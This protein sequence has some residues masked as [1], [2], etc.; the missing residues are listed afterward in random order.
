MLAVSV[1][2]E[3]W[4]HL[5]Y[6]SGSPFSTY[7]NVNDFFEKWDDRY[8]YL[9]E[10]CERVLKLL[11]DFKIQ[12]TFFVVADVVDNYPE[13]AEKIVDGGHE[14]ACHG[15]HHECAID[16]KTKRAIRGVDNFERQ[17]MVAK[18]KLEEVSKERIIG[19]RAPSAYIAGWMIDSLE[20]MGFKYDSSVSVNSLY[21]KSDEKLKNVTTVPYYPVKGGL[22]SGEKRD[23]IEMP[24]PYFKLVGFKFPTG[25]GPFLRFGGARYIKL[26]LRQS[27]KRGNTVF[28]FH[29]IDISDERFPGG[30]S[31]R[32]PFYWAIKGKTVE[33]RIRYILKNIDS[34]LGTCRDIW[35][36]MR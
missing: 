16:P 35:E 9:S 6:V 12:A 10:P 31:T 27:L 36:R 25:G 8:D 24:W 2:I 23:I 11:D 22:K 18:K 29:P 15:L 32:R 21:N 20:R 3:D 28:Y 4:Y 26:G 33:K 1:D 7:S 17:I 14:I 34:E 5:P 13:M 19:F 30:F